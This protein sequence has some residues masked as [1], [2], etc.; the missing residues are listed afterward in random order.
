MSD[1][2]LMKLAVAGVLALCAS[3]CAGYLVNALRTRKRDPG[4]V[5]FWGVVFCI[6]LDCLLTF[7]NSLPRP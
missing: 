2:L 5:V 1:Q 3:T 6:A 7:V 4:R